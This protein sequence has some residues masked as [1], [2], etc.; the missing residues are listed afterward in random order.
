MITFPKF[1][2]SLNRNPLKPLEILKI[3][4]QFKP[5]NV[6]KYVGISPQIE[7]NTFNY[8]HGIKSTIANYAKKNDLKVKFHALE[9]IDDEIL[10]S[11][12]KKEI[13]AVHIQHP[14]IVG[15]SFGFDSNVA[16]VSDP[17]EKNTTLF[18]DKY[19]VDPELRAN[20]GLESMGNKEESFARQI[21]KALE[22]VVHG[23][24][25]K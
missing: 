25:E 16:F 5:I 12:D 7:G 24:I 3:N 15:D 21:Y 9:G 20:K 14:T 17:V 23:K 10:M 11:V 8:L 19:D 1:S 2:V 13:K 6:E 22:D 18:V 4:K